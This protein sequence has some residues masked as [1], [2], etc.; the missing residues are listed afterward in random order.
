MTYVPL[1]QYHKMYIQVHG[2]YK[3]NTVR[4][5]TLTLFLVCSY[6]PVYYSWKRGIRVLWTHSS[7]FYPAKDKFSNTNKRIIHNSCNCLFI[8]FCAKYIQYISLFCYLPTALTGPVQGSL[9]SSII[10]TFCLH[11]PSCTNLQNTGKL[12]NFI[13]ML[14]Y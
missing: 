11:G 5:R 8:M 6:A 2:S 7:I 3:E 9:S 1:K 13:P 10:T 12:V 4:F 14:K